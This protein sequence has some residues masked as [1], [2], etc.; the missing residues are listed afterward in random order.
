MNLADQFFWRERLPE[1][2]FEPFA[3]LEMPTKQGYR[4]GFVR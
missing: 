3:S 4:D 2:P 1:E